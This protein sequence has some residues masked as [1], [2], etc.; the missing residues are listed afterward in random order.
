MDII[1][2]TFTLLADCLATEMHVAR[3]VNEISFL[4]CEMPFDLEAI[5]LIR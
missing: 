1:L 5:K 2:I 3:A 4:I